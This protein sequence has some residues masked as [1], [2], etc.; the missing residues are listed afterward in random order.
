MTS[1]DEA[2]GEPGANLEDGFG[3]LVGVTF[4]LLTVAETLASLVTSWALG[5]RVEM[6]ILIGGL[7]VLNIVLAQVLVDRLFK[8][9][10]LSRSG[11]TREVRGRA[12]ALPEGAVGDEEVVEVRFPKS[13]VRF[14]F[15]A[16]LGGCLFCTAVLTLMP[17]PDTATTSA[18]IFLIGLFGLGTVNIWWDRKPQAWADRDGITGYPTGPHLFRRFVPWSEVDA[19]E[20]ETFYNTF[21]KPVIVRPTLKDRDGRA[22][23]VMNLQYTQLEDQERLV[24]YIKA[25]LPKPKDDP[26]E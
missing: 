4:I 25:K 20:I 6:G 2:A 16:C 7:T 14:L 23:M 17:R 11:R 12:S 3:C 19:C 5:F 21:G 1:D 18:G 8:R 15:W 13:F 22:L 9:F 26:W 24:K 10:G